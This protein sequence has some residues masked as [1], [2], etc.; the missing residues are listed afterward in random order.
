MGK[1][2]QGLAAVVFG[3]SA[4]L[5]GCV[6]NAEKSNQRFDEVRSYLEKNHGNFDSEAMKVYLDPKGSYEKLSPAEKAAV[7]KIDFYS[8]DKEDREKIL[9]ECPYVR[10]KNMTLGDKIWLWELKSMCDFGRVMDSILGR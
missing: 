5:G 2:Y 7:D 3:A 8:F 4:F 1:I 10:T 9:A 6:P